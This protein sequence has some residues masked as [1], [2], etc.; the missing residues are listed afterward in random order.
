MG[1][2]TLT[3]QMAWGQE[4]TGMGGRA[5]RGWSGVA[6]AY[7]RR[8]NAVC[9]YWTC[10]YSIIVISCGVPQGFV[11]GRMSCITTFE[12]CLFSVSVSHSSTYMLFPSFKS[13]M[14]NR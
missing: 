12:L 8:E 9:R 2:L 4:A 6:G 7:A 3:C 14:G 1:L 5:V 10:P 13:G 11:L